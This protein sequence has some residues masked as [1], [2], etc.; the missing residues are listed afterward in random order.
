WLL[1]A[2]GF[3]VHAETL[4]PDPAWQ[5]G[6]LDNGFSWQLLTTPQRPSDRI[7]LRLIVNTG[8]LVESAQQTGFSHLLPRLAMVHNTALDTN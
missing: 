1:A 3:G 6:K 4:Q 2:S 8:S 7:E 5:E